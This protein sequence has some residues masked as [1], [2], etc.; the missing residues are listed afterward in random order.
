M[1]SRRIST[2]LL[3]A[4]VLAAGNGLCAQT[5]P[6]EW[7]APMLPP[8]ANRPAAD[9][10]HPRWVQETIE[11]TNRAHIARMLEGHADVVVLD[12]G[13][14]QGFRDG[15]VCLVQR[16]NTPVARLMVVATEE[17]RCAALIT[18]LPPDVIIVPGDEVRVSVL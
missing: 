7:H 3:A 11:P 2:C 1:S 8:G 17:N 10:D 12:S 14:Y 15:V 5:A 16:G 4:A 18:N 13:Y 6:A 9:T